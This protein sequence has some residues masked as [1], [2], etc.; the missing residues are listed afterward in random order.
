MSNAQIEN[1]YRNRKGPWFGKLLEGWKQKPDDRDLISFTEQA[2]KRDNSVRMFSGNVSD[3]VKNALKKQNPV[4]GVRFELRNGRL[5]AVVDLIVAHYEGPLI[6]GTTYDRS[7]NSAIPADATLLF[8]IELDINMPYMLP[9]KK[10]LFEVYTSGETLRARSKGIDH[11]NMFIN[12]AIPTEAQARNMGN[13]DNNCKGAC[14]IMGYNIFD[15]EIRELK[16]LNANTVYF[17]NP[18]QR[19][20]NDNY[21]GTVFG[22]DGSIHMFTGDGAHA[23]LKGN[24]YV[25]NANRMDVNVEERNSRGLLSSGSSE[26]NFDKI[27]PQSNVFFP[28]PRYLPPITKIVNL[29]ASIKAVIEVIA[30]AKEFMEN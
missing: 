20:V 11:S 8:G 27:Y 6:D 16:T 25:I 9:N 2:Y 4:S 23:K 7:S 15:E 18:N 29:A 17:T 13:V 28:Y 19:N 26:N 24:Q 21:S 10:H 3:Q 5:V 14:G 12:R 1:T 22:P 30:K